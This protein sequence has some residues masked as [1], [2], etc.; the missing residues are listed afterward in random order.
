MAVKRAALL[1][2]ALSIFGHQG[3]S[4]PDF[5]KKPVMYRRDQD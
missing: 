1:C 2:S 4:E 5:F 3:S